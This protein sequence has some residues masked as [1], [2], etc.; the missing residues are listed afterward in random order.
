MCEYLD[1]TN[2]FLLQGIL[3]D[4]SRGRLISLESLGA[5]FSIK[6]SFT[7]TSS[8]ASLVR[9]GHAHK[10]CWQLIYPIF[11]SLEIVF[12]N[13]HDSGM[14]LLSAGEGLIVPPYNWIEIK[15][16]KAMDCAVV[17]ASENY[18]T[19]DYIYEKPLI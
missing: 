16:L 7:I 1:T 14:V 11:H 6:R 5:V 2:P 13:K 17:L 18:S 10:A 15:F 12:K 19:W 4:D 8:E 9:G 3:I